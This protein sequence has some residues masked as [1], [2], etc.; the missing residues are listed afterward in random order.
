MLVLKSS[1]LGGQKGV[2]MFA[3]VGERLPCPRL[4]CGMRSLATRLG[5]PGEKDEISTVLSRCA[6]A[7]FTLHCA[8][9]EAGPDLSLSLLSKHVRRMANLDW[10]G[11]T[12][13]LELLFHSS[14]SYG[15][16]LIPAA[17]SLRKL[18]FESEGDVSQII[19]S[20]FK[21]APH[22]KEFHWISS[23]PISH[24]A[25][26][27]FSASSPFS[28][29]E[30]L[31]LESR[32]KRSEVVPNGEPAQVRDFIVSFPNLQDLSLF[33][34]Y[35]DGW[36]N[37]AGLP[38]TSINGLTSLRLGQGTSA[39]AI[40]FLSTVA[41]PELQTIELTDFPYPTAEVFYY[42]SDTSKFNPLLSLCISKLSGALT[43]SAEGDSGREANFYASVDKSTTVGIMADGAGLH[44]VERL[45]LEG[46]IFY[47]LTPF[48]EASNVTTLVL[49]DITS[50]PLYLML[51]RGPPPSTIFPSLQTLV[52][53]GTATSIAFVSAV[54]FTAALAGRWIYQ[55]PI[56]RLVIEE[57]VESDVNYQILLQLQHIQELVLDDVLY[58]ADEYGSEDEAEF[59]DS[60]SDSENGEWEEFWEYEGEVMFWKSVCD[61]ISDDDDDD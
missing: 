30:R 49:H 10:K 22:L 11:P 45:E 13:A 57:P 4:S 38:P 33:G 28:C 56:H 51:S 27:S 14:I 20:L 6:N 34:T 50:R 48:I 52:L 41:L 23:S 31:S 59:T 9:K 24:A 58:L 3:R 5:S 44:H 39:S 47:D 55:T 46:S 26:P 8:R 40:N 1:I 18:T 16:N 7:T 12:K 53:R 43:L 37:F 17:S 21:S 15:S 25:F 61:H 2:L 35:F 32:W 60:D 36:E 19:A 54:D 42:P 29:I